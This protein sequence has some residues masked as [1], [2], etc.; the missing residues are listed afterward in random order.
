MK[1]THLTIA[2]LVA[3]MAAA[4]AAAQTSFETA[5]ENDDGEIS[6]DEFYGTV[7]DLG[8]YSDWDLDADGIIDVDELDSLDF[9]DDFAADYVWDV[10]NDGYVD[11]VEFYE[12]VYVGFDDDE[13][14]HWDGLEWDD[15]GDEG[16]W[17][18]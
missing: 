17:D 11:A 7:S 18:I 15:A 6:K 8:I 16:F 3:V 14:G 5:D 9:D 10:D 13:S 12:G 2:A 4:P 1:I